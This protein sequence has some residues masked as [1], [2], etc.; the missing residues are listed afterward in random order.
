MRYNYFK[1]IEQID[2]IIRY[3]EAYMKNNA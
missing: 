3:E 2:P 1:G